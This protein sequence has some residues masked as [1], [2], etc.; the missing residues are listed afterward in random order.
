MNFK[1]KVVYQ[2]YPKSFKDANN[3]GIGDLQGIIE[4]LDYIQCLGVDYIWITPIYPSPQND[5]GYDIKDYYGIDP[6]FGTME[7]FE[8]LVKEAKKRNIGIMMDMVFN[9]TSTH[10]AWFQK[11]IQGDPEYMDRYIFKKGRGGNP[12][13]NWISKFE[14]SAWQYV[15]ALDSYY[16]R[17]FHETQA[18][19]NWKNEHVRKEAANI[20]NFWIDKGVKGFRFDVINLIDKES[21]ENDPNGNGKTL[22]TD[23]PMVHT[24]LKE[25]HIN[26]FGK[27]EDIITVG[28][29]SSTSIENCILYTGESTQELTMAFNFHHLKVDYDDQDRWKINHFDFVKLKQV[30]T[31]WQL[32]MQKGNGWNALFWCCHDQPRIISRYGDDKVYPKESAKMLATAIHMMRGTPYIYQGEEIGMTNAYFSR[33]EQYRDIAAINAYHTMKEIGKTE[34]EIFSFLQ[35]NARDNARTPM[36]WNAKQNAGFSE[37]TP[38]I[39]VNPNHKT[40]HVEENLQD[41]DS[42]FYY[43]Q[44]LIQLR[45]EYKV[46]QEGSFVPL[47]EDHKQIFAYKRILGDEELQ[48]Y[49]NF[50]SASCEVELSI[51]DCE[52]LLSNVN[53]KRIIDKIQLSPY[54]ALVLRRVK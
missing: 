54:E 9:H 43:Y 47:L 44:K 46:I 15:E 12:P 6:M 51:D 5:N 16:L 41:K 45:K 32:G 2:I 10:H 1:D 42:V 52:I 25:L 4:N 38:W 8:V 49:L 37:H 21:F 36:Q 40:L 27:Y 53:R 17:L 30:L 23:R 50:F 28:E 39:D 20:V 35:S 14:G 24:Y 29:F 22:Y 18:D 11:A 19:L 26:S 7:E 48:V 13:T 31:S 33:I 3:D 34:E